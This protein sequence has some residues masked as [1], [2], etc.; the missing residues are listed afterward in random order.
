M[1][2]LH[3]RCSRECG[4]SCRVW[5]AQRRSCITLL[6]DATRTKSKSTGRVDA[7][8]LVCLRLVRAARAG[9]AVEMVYGL[10]GAALPRT[11]SYPIRRE[12]ATRR[13]GKC[14][15][16]GVF[17]PESCSVPSGARAASPATSTTARAGAGR[18]AQRAPARRR[19]RRRNCDLSGSSRRCLPSTSDCSRACSRAWNRAW[20]DGDCA[21]ERWSLA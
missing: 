9:W 14:L 1:T 6:Q 13:E 8:A 21:A 20:R 19:S 12:L 7:T 16:R 3:E 17:T 15:A 10:R 2:G 18:K 11:K 5:T 4:A